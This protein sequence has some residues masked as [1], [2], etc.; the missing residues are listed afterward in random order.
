MSVSVAVLGVVAVPVLEAV[1][2]AVSVAVFGAVAVSEG[3]AVP[4]SVAETVSGTGAGAASVLSPEPHALAAVAASKQSPISNAFAVAVVGGVTFGSLPSQTARRPG[5]AGLQMHLPFAAPG[6]LTLGLVLALLPVATAHAADVVVFGDSWAEGSADELAETLVARGRGDITVA[7]YGVGGTTAEL[8]AGQPNALPDAVSANPDARWVW[9]SIGGNDVFGHYAAGNGANAAADNERNIR[10]ILDALFARHP[11]IKVVFFGYDFVNFEQSQRCIEQALLVFG[12][13]TFTPTINQ[14]MLDDIG[15]VQETI[16]ADYPNATYVS[17]VWGTLQAAGGIPGAPTTL[18]P[19]PSRYMDDCIHPNHLGY[20]LIHGALYDAYWGQPA[21][22]AAIVGGGAACVGTSVTLRDASTGAQSRRWSVDGA[23][24]GSSVEIAVELTAPGPR[25]VTLRVDAGAWDDSTSVTVSGSAGPEVSVSGPGEVVEGALVTY[26]AEGAAAAFAWSVEGG[27]LEA[28][29]GAEATVRWGGPG[30]GAV[31]L[32]A[33]DEM[34]CE[35]RAELPVAVL[36]AV[37]GEGLPE[38]EPCDL[39]DPC[40]V[41]RCEGGACVRVGLAPGCCHADSDCPAPFEVCALEEGYCTGILCVPCEVDADCRR[42]GNRCLELPSGR[43]CGADCSARE[44]TCPP[45][46]VCADLGEGLR[47]CVP[48]AGD[49]TCAPEFSR[50]CR[51]GEVLW[52]DS[53]G[54]TGEI[55]VD[56]GE[57]GCVDGECC[58][59]GSHAAEGECVAEPVSEPAPEV[60][61]PAPEIVEPAP[62]VAE[63]AP[64]VAEPSVEPMPEPAPDVASQ[65]PGSDVSGTDARAAPPGVEGLRPGPEAPLVTAPEPSPPGQGTPVLDSGGACGGCARGTRP[66]AGMAALLL[67]LIGLCLPRRLA[68]QGRARALHL[69]SA[70]TSRTPASRSSRVVAST[71]ERP[72]KSGEGR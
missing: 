35:A 34:G 43:A 38:G 69:G 15:A 21:P 24:A 42:S 27:T 19:S 17:T 65:S 61:E 37:C 5:I 20:L 63:P 45:Q 56:C 9:L 54:R 70:S 49:C 7:G 4:V 47:Q 52:L 6:L 32:T 23:D 67:L 59:E 28:S 22:V 31:R 71:D 16:A 26:R 10:A 8:W 1:S 14:I 36:A 64:E 11:D 68:E 51:G 25:T 33:G 46:F 41:A 40:L 53:C 44:V 12:V 50:T 29:N 2:G 62:E 66:G 30:S 72:A 57:R 13:G 3:V 48:A 60:A 18:V 58:P 39:G 55:L